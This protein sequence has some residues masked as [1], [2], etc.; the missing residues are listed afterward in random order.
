[1]SHSIII[2]EDNTIQLQELTTIINHYSMFHY[3]LFSIDFSSQVPTDILDYIKKNPKETRIYFL[4]ICLNHKMN[5]IDLAVEIRKIEPNSKIIFITTHD[6]MATQTFQF[7]VEALGFITKDQNIE[8]YRDEIQD[9]LNII[10]KRIG[11]KKE[12]EGKRFIFKIGSETNIID[13]DTILYLT[14]SHIPHRIN[15]ITENECYEFYGKIKAIEKEYPTLFKA[16][17]AFLI[18]PKNISRIDYKNRVIWFGEN[19][20]VPFSIGKGK[21][22]KEILQGD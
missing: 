9:V 11:K 3:D 1:M 5:G 16:S 21:A 13:V 19:E 7:K 10:E 2:C 14:T 6:E 8:G 20:S 15:L 12:K 22:L 4:D 17:R 18:N